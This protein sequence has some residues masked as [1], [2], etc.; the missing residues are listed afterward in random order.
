MAYT[1]KQVMCEA[2]SKRASE[3][4][5][6]PLRVID[7][8]ETVDFAGEIETTVWI[9]DPN[10]ILGYYILEGSLSDFIDEHC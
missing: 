9:D 10:D 5:S 4:F 1:I 2:L 6:R 3:V 7:F 8:R